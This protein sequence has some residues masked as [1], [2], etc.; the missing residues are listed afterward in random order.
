MLKMYKFISNKNAAEYWQMKLHSQLIYIPP[1]T[2]PP[3]LP[4][5]IP[6]LWPTPDNIHVK[7]DISPGSMVYEQER[8]TTNWF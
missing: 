8:T 4:N 7:M 2:L 1:N 3:F 6:L 5:H